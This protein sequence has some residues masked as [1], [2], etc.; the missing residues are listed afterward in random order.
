MSGRGGDGARPPATCIPRTASIASDR[1]AAR[2]RTASIPSPPAQPTAPAPRPLPQLSVDG[3]ERPDNPH[4][5]RL[6]RA[7]VDAHF[8][9]VVVVEEDDALGADGG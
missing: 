8:G 3:L 4:S 6:G 2:P 5:A 9:D 7:P 1:D